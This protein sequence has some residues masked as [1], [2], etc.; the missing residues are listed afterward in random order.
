MPVLVDSAGLPVGVGGKGVRPAVPHVDSW[1]KDPTEWPNPAYS[2]PPCMGQRQWRLGG[3]TPLEADHGQRLLVAAILGAILGWERRS[4][5]RPAGIRTMALVALGAAS[6]TL[7][8]T[9]AFISG[10]MEWDAS[11]IAA[12]IPSGVGFLGAGVIW[13][14]AGLSGHHAGHEVRGLTTATTVWLSAAVGCAAGGKMYFVSIFCMAISIVILRYAPRMYLVEETHHGGNEQHTEVGASSDCAP[15]RDTPAADPSQGSNG[16]VGS[17]NN[18]SKV[19]EKVDAEDAIGAYHES[20]H[21]LSAAR[22]ISQG[23][24][25][26]HTDG[27]G[28]ANDVPSSYRS[29]R[30]AS[31]RTELH[32]PLLA[33]VNSLPHR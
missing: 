7:A 23:Q 16:R 12:A 30:G 4:S 8:S 22:S 28:D 1:T 9:F 33:P 21:A 18:K 20:P 19:E 6:F 25:H 17:G 2:F 14:G 5:D 24:R 15:H 26:G 13:K 10:P 27:G 32:M 29:Q 11:R 3:L 31:Y